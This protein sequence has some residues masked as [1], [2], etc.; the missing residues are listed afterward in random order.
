MNKFVFVFLGL[1]VTLISCDGR[2]TKA[3]LFKES[4][5]KFK[6]SIGILE[7]VKYVPEM[8][9]ETITDTLLSN[10][11]KVNIK[12][13]TDMDHNIINQFKQDSIAY[14]YYYRELYSQITIKKEGNKDVNLLIDKKFIAKHDASFEF[15]KEFYSRATYYSIWFDELNSTFCDKVA[16]IMS[17][18]KPESDDCLMFKVIIDSKGNYQVNE[19]QYE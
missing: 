6:D 3:D 10:G 18:C 2:K 16:L 4:V 5:T 7:I 19:F 11:F 12:S 8:Y 14:K 9:S 13:F 17:V 1:I 15:N